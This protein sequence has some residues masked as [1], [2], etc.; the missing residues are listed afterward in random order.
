MAMTQCAQCG[1]ELKAPLTVAI[2]ATPDGGRVPV[3]VCSPACRAAHDRA[4]LARKPCVG[5]GCKERFVPS[6]GPGR[7]QLY[8]D[9]S[10][11]KATDRAM[12]RAMAAVARGKLPKTVEDT[13]ETMALVE[14]LRACWGG[15]R[16]EVTYGRPFPVLDPAPAPELVAASGRFLTE[17]SHRLAELRRHERESSDAD[18]EQGQR[19]RYRQ[20]VAG[21]KL[22]D[23]TWREEALAALG[24]AA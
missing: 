21:R 20:I 12:R 22:A 16:A 6:T 2:Q 18:W 17:L 15:R 23:Q 3:Q 7:P 13:R 4:G 14:F 8:H 10:C 5:Y 1:G 24:E 9:E 11:R 19:A